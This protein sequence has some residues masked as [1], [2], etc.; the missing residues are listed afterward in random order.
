[1]GL[2]VSDLFCDSDLGLFREPFFMPVGYIIGTCT[3]R[4]GV[5][6]AIVF[7]AGE[8]QDPRPAGKILLH[9]QAES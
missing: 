4:I 2:A 8:A 6:G 7:P 1:M 9:R 3:H 5:A